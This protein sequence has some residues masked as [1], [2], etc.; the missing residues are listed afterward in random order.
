MGACL[1]MVHKVRRAVA[2]RTWS[3]NAMFGFKRLMVRVVQLENGQQC[4]QKR[5]S[6]DQTPRN[7]CYRPT[8]RLLKFDELKRLLRLEFSLRLRR[9]QTRSSPVE[10][11][12]PPPRFLQ[13]NQL[14]LLGIKMKLS[15]QLGEENT[16][17]EK[18]S[19]SR[20]TIIAANS[21]K[22]QRTIVLTAMFQ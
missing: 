16:Q 15:K 19:F 5:S 13:V 2:T 12:A 9:R 17:Y 4:H 21:R 8:S 14:W 22:R 3:T 11:H 6:A 7:Q 18:K 1:K 10:H 20:L